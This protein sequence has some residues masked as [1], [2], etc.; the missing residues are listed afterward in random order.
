VNGKAASYKNPEKSSKTFGE[1]YF[2]RKK[3]EALVIVPAVH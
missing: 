2:F 3:K 1:K